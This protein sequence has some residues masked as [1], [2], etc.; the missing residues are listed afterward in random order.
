MLSRTHLAF[1]I[2]IYL[3][4]INFLNINNKLLFFIAI[5]FFSIFADIDYHN[6][7]ISR[8]TRP[9]SYLINVISK[10]RGIF[11]TIYIPILLYLLF[12]LINTDIAN[13]TLLGYISH[14]ALDS[15]NISGTRLFYPLHNKK[16]K[17]VIKTG[18]F[19]ENLLFIFIVIFCIAL[20]I[21]KFTI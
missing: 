13:A 11:H 8:K 10:H 19:L 4:S 9:F 21:K 5:L 18:S 6:S 1:G 2:L 12:T 7:K 15:L 3:I 17:G 16:I 14:I 20:L